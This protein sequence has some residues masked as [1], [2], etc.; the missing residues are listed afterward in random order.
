MSLVGQRRV[1]AAGG[2]VEYQDSPGCHQGAG[3]RQAPALATGEGDAILADRRVEPL[4]QGGHAGLQAERRALRP[5][6]SASV[7]SGRPRTRLDRT[8]PAN[9]CARWSASAQTARAVGLAQV[10][11]R[12]LLRAKSEPSSSGQYRRSAVTRLDLP[13]PLDPVTATRPPAGRY[14]FTPSRAR[15]RPGP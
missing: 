12:R 15:G 8:V 9:I 3:D 4:G 6:I 14:T 11:R 2:L 7:A 13:A 5:V 1:E 10:A